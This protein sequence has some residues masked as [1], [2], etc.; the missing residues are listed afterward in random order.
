M[1]MVLALVVVAVVVV[2]VLSPLLFM[3]PLP[4]SLL[5]QLALPP[6]ALCPGSSMLAAVM[7]ASPP[8]PLPRDSRNKKV[9]AWSSAHTYHHAF[10]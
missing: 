7:P 4:I 6:T 2:G 5:L 8:S 1:L 10:L 9:S 3:P